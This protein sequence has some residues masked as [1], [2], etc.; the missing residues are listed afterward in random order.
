MAQTEAD[1]QQV[2]FR[3]GSASLQA[4]NL[5]QSLVDSAQAVCA[6][7]EKYT[8]LGVASPEGSYR[9]N[10][11]LALRRAQAIV[12]ALKKRTGLAD[13]MFQVKTQVADVSTLRD[14]AAQDENLPEK[15]AVMALL[16]AGDA[17]GATL[18]KL[19]R[20]GDGTPYLY[21]KDRL[22][23]YLR[24]S[25]S[26]D[27]D[28]EAYHPNI[29]AKS[30]PQIVQR[31]YQALKTKVVKPTPVRSAVTQ[32]VAV[33]QEPA[34]SA[35]VDKPDSAENKAGFSE[36]KPDASSEGKGLS[37]IPWVLCLLLLL[38]LLAAVYYYR[39]KVSSLENELAVSQQSKDLSG[40]KQNEVEARLAATEKALAEA[41]QKFA[42]AQEELKAQ[43]NTDKEFYKSGEALF[44]YLQNGGVTN[45][46]TS[47]Q[48]RA[49]IDYYRLQNSTLI[50]TLET[51]YDKLPLNHIL[52]QI[53]VDM[54]K[55]DEEIQRIMNV[56][57]TTIRSYRFRIKNRKLKT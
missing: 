31:D 49:F 11:R 52:F 41:E 55:T 57:Q 1:D 29:A 25:V 18:A 9:Q 24:A 33:N 16:S 13:S 2:F 34:K 51:E 45:G 44:S 36:N 20:L 40:H 32:K 50:H 19:K 4:G 26:S 28:L 39:R 56:S 5:P 22:F 6:R 21:I 48:T 15:E 42:A 30:Q 3:V 38:A 43:K 7:G 35:V 46:W 10:S 23:P 12:K 54:G 27:K 17:T 14:L 37:W 53:L 8:V 47:D